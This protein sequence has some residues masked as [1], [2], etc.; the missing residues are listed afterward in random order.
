MND[1]LKHQ[2]WNDKIPAWIPDPNAVQFLR[3]VVTYCETIDDLIDRDQPVTNDAIIQMGMLG[4]LSIPINDFYRV[5]HGVLIPVM[6]AGVNAWLQ[7]NTFEQS[8]DIEERRM[9]YVLRG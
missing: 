4:L 2:L 1:L 6:L 9:A 8:M 3:D 5:H 7:A